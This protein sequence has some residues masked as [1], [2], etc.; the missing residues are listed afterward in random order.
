MGFVR[1]I[2]GTGTVVLRLFEQPRWWGKDYGRM[3]LV[4]ASFETNVGREFLGRD[5]AEKGGCGGFGGEGT[6]CAGW[7]GR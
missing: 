5:A 7:W 4:D 1:D 6:R 3:R 2:R